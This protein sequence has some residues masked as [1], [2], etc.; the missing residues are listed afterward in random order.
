MEDWSNRTWVISEYHIARKRYGKI[1]FWFN[2][3]S[4]P[5]LYGY[6]FFEFDF[7][8]QHQTSKSMYQH[9]L[10]PAG[11][12]ATQQQDEQDKQD[13]LAQQHP[14][15]AQMFTLT[16]QFKTSMRRRLTQR[17]VLEMMLQTR[18]SKSEDRFHAIV[19]LASKYKHHIKDKH[20]ISSWGISDMLSVRLKL[21]EWLDTKDRL[22]LLFSA[23]RPQQ[24]QV[25]VQHL[26][27]L[28]TFASDL[29]AVKPG[30]LKFIT[31]YYYLNFDLDNSDSVRLERGTGGLDVIWLCPSRGYFVHS[32]ERSWYD[33]IGGKTNKLW[34]QLG[35]DPVTD[36]LDAVSIPLAVQYYELD[37]RD[38]DDYDDDND[39]TYDE[40][41]AIANDVSRSE[42]QL[43]GSLEKNVWIVYHFCNAYKQG[44]IYPSRPCH[45]DQ[46][47]EG[48]R[49]Y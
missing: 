47:P 19:P 22:N 31:Q 34:Q 41:D 42:I 23:R 3:L 4:S 30:L 20:S 5:E 8:N 49:I 14:Y 36:T 32:T 29:K 10:V 1:K 21:L 27:L 40:E 6:R 9:V 24:Q 12:S 28:P 48:F 39:V 18:A 44:V 45:M 26:P 11:S 7:K 13:P 33:T 37:P 46:Y 35:L 2:Q 43:I 17:T 25:K 16:E 38:D 15:T